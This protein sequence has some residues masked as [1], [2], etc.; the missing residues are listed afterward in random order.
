MNS[1]FTIYIMEVTNKQTENTFNNF[2]KI[3]KGSGY[4]FFS[5]SDLKWKVTLGTANKWAIS[6]ASVVEPFHFGPAPALASQ[7]GG[8]SSSPVVHNL[9]L[10]KN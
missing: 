3:W 6:A 10:K 2:N 7:D 5:E 9:L 1:V 8:S 4:I